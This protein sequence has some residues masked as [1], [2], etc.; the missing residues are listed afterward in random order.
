[1]L[2]SDVVGDKN[3]GER[4]PMKLLSNMDSQKKLASSR[5]SDPIGVEGKE[6]DGNMPS[7]MASKPSV[8]T[9]SR[10]AKLHNIS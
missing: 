3:V 8:L 1:M 5:F 4:V 7:S 9:V 10:A 6:N 2:D